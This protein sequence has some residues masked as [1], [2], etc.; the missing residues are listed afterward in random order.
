MTGP[1][2]TSLR[3]RKDRH[4]LA[5]Y[6]SLGGYRAARQ[7]LAMPP[8]AIV[9]QV[10]RS[11]IRGRGG[12][13]FPA[14]TK[15]GFL[16]PPGAMP[17]YLCVNADE[18]E[19]GTFKDRLLLEED[20][21][22][23]LE[24]IV[25]TCV[26]T[27]IHQAY[28]YLRGEYDLS[29]RRLEEALAEAYAAHYLGKGIFGGPFDLEVQLFRGAGA[30]ICGE[31]TALLESLE[32]KKGSPR[33][34]PPF[35]AVKGLFGGPTVINNVETL[36]ALPWILLHGGDAYAA[37][38]TP[39]STGTRLFAV[40]GHVAKPGVYELP[41]GTPLLTLIHDCAGGMKNG[42]PL[43]AGIPGGSATPVLTAAEAAKARLDFESMAELGS[44]L[45]AGAVIVIG[46]DTCMVKALAVLTRF[47]AHE[48][49]GQCTPCREGTGW[50]N[51]I[52]TRLEAGQGKESDIDLAYRLAKEMN[53]RTICALAAALAMPVM[54]FLDKFRP[55]FLAHARG[56]KK[57]CPW[58]K[59]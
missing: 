41:L 13:G 19:P 32:G 10:K 40:S 5:T 46:G 43:K 35:P 25:I 51:R 36:A 1:L 53:G 2:L 56:E 24:G 11:G 38:G 27:G 58:V 28:I 18:G 48:S 30:Y 7:A 31:E 16:P 50:V 14:G 6:E 20:P 15:W 37:I 34:K 8:A 55:E 17:R 44:M 39:K 57:D 4:R 42:L 26:A 49:C 47:Y 3:D 22:L 33:V 21:H 29:R 52:I 45:G 59:V 9:D 12:A 54:S 23:L